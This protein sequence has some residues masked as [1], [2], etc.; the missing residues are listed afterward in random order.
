MKDREEFENIIKDII[1]NKTVQEMKKYRQHCDVSCFEHC[2]RTA[3]YC[4]RFCKFMH[5]DYV[6]VT[7][8][9]MLHDLFLYDWRVKSDRKGL[10]AF[11][12]PKTAYENAA[13]I[14]DLS[15]KE[16]DIIVKHMWP[17]TVAFPRYK[18]SYVLTLMDKYSATK[19]S[20]EYAAKCFKSYE[21]VKYAHVVLAILMFSVHK[22]GKLL[23]AALVRGMFMF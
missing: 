1:S 17:V 10:H 23:L 16:K 19:E 3:Y 18:E 9:A 11:T 22:K 8:A 4:Y 13:K 5:W 15:D 21:S 14:F 7:R 12:H 6:A 20:F 2:Y